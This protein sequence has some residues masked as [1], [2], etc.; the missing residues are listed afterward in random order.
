MPPSVRTPGGQPDDA[1]VV[2][3]ERVRH[4]WKH[5]QWRSNRKAAEEGQGQLKLHHPEHMLLKRV[6]AA[7]DSFERA[8]QSV[9]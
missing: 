8:V 5:V 6:S 2:E 3:R 9:A 7:E 1:A 4:V